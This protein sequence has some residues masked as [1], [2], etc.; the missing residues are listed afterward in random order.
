MQRPEEVRNRGEGGT[1]L[2]W[3]LRLLSLRMRSFNVMGNQASCSRIL[4]RGFQLSSG[5]SKGFRPKAS[6]PG[7]LSQHAIIRVLH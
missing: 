5:S 3:V 2:G 4:L 6:S 7:R 1:R